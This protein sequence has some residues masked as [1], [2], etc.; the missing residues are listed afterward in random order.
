MAFWKER[1]TKA[2]NTVSKGQ[3][4]PLPGDPGGKLGRVAE[5]I[6]GNLWRFCFQGRGARDTEEGT[7]VRVFYVRRERSNDPKKF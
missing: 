1:K 4:G 7:R 6:E 3:K 2:L 5:L